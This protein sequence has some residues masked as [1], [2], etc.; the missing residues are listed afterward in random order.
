MKLTFQSAAIL[1]A[2]VCFALA[3]VWMFSPEII[4]SRWG[5]EYSSSVALVSRRMAASFAGIAVMFFLARKAEP[6]PARSAL[7]A[8]FV[9]V[10]FI[11]AV[12]AFVELASGQATTGILSA[13]FIEVT[14]PLVL[15]YAVRSKKLQPRKLKS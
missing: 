2:L 11:L 15:L 13:V 8:G 3:V 1:V 7:V 9:T 10:S 4:L 6:S 14:L 12:L 5:V